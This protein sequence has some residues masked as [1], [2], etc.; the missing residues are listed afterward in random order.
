MIK[1]ESKKFLSDPD[2]KASPGWW[3]K[4][5]KILKI[6]MIVSTHIIQKLCSRSGEDIKLYLAKIQQLK[7]ENIVS[8]KSKKLLLF[9]NYN[10]VPLQFDMVSGKTYDFQGTKEICIQKTSGVKMQVTVLMS[11]LSNG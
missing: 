2:F 10:E 1:D 4:T 8:S 7:M 6:V 3:Q 9:G 5:R 11:I